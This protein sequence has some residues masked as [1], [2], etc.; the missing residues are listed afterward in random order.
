MNRDG[1]AVEIAVDEPDCE[2][3]VGFEPRDGCAVDVQAWAA[4]NPR[5]S[6]KNRVPSSPYVASRVLLEDD[7]WN[8]ELVNPLVLRAALG[9]NTV[10]DF[11]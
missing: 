6:G 9:L 1:V 4:G 3:V 8:Y 5:I 10:R 7:L 2:A 11:T